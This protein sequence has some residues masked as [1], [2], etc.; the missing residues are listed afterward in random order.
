[1]SKK[2]LARKREKLLETQPSKQRLDAKFRY[3]M[4]VFSYVHPSPY[5]LKIKK[6]VNPIRIGR[7]SFR[8]SFTLS[9]E[10]GVATHFKNLTRQSF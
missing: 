10:E 2:F 5:E 9:G 8:S 1:V 7:L 6:A 3:L 4:K